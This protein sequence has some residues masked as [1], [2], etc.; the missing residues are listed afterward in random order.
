[1]TIK[2]DAQKALA[3]ANRVA[4]TQEANLR[5]MLWDRVSEKAK[6]DEDF[7]KELVIDPKRAVEIEAKQISALQGTDVTPAVVEKV[8]A[9]VRETYSS[10]VP[11]LAADRVE[12]LIFGT[13]ED[14][15]RAYTITLLLSQVLFYAGLAM[16]VAGFV[17]GLISGEK[18]ISLF[19]GSGGIA[20]MLIS[21]LIVSPLDRVQNSAG[22]LVQLQMAYLSYYKQLY[23]L[24]GNNASV[25]RDD[26]MVYSKEIDRVTLSLMGS[27][28]SYVDRN[29]G[30]NRAVRR[31]K[32]KGSKSVNTEEGNIEASVGVGD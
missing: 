5:E 8:A 31:G 7:R 24:G 20:S 14:I 6:V 18:L 2:F 29:G 4:A 12:N 25:A 15:K 26:A 3:R 28:Q 21:S 13:I 11:D 32:K 1:M 17:A 9:R 30:T 23:L 10:I 27:V 16:V 19:F 22:N